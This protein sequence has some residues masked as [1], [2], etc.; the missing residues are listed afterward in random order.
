MYTMNT[1]RQEYNTL[2]L[3]HLK[4]RI[5]DVI[6]PDIDVKYGCILKLKSKFITI[7]NDQLCI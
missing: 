3:E 5:P 6:I 4:S 7:L 2:T 1:I